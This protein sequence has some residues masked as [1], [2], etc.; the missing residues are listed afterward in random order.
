M[1][2]R[3]QA[4]IPLT[5]HAPGPIR[6]ATLSAEIL[7]HIES[8]YGLIG[9]YL[10]VPLETFE[11]SFMRAVSPAAEVAV[12]CN[13]AIAW[14]NYHDRFADGEYLPDGEEK[15]LLRALVAISLGEDKPEQWGIPEEQGCRLAACY[16]ELRRF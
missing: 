12:W 10:G 9:S 7:E 3:R 6:H 5:R 11:I 2:R 14:D 4:A 13:I 8:I 1:G 15:K 16:E